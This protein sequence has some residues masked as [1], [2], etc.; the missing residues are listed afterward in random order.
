VLGSDWTVL[1]WFESFNGQLCGVGSW[2]WTGDSA[3]EG[4]P[5][6]GAKLDSTERHAQPRP[7]HLR[8]GPTPALHCVAPWTR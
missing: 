4:A 7:L 6:L 8:R 5:Q 3:V 2:E 1:G